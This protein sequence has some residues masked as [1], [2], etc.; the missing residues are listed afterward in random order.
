MNSITLHIYVAQEQGV[1]ATPALKATSSCLVCLSLV[2]RNEA[3]SRRTFFFFFCSLNRVCITSKFSIS[4][5]PCTVLLSLLS[6]FNFPI[7]FTFPCFTLLHLLLYSLSPP[8]TPPHSPPPPPPPPPFSADS[9]LLPS[10]HD[11]G[12]ELRAVL[13]HTPPPVHPAV[14][15]GWSEASLCAVRGAV[16]SAGYTLVLPKMPQGTQAGRHPQGIHLLLQEDG[17]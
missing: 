15:Q 17:T 3:V 12:L 2:R 6:Q 14:G 5:L 1:L 7:S 13:L 16:P 11:Q 10:S 9:F 4:S 8:S